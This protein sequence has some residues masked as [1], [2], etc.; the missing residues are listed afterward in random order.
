MVGEYFIGWIAIF[1]LDMDR[2]T[3]CDGDYEFDRT[4]FKVQIAKSRVQNAF[5][6]GSVT[7]PYKRFSGTCRKLVQGKNDGVIGKVYECWNEA[8]INESK[9]S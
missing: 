1:P 8:N 3:A 6:T 5:V 2:V 4:H 7:R 9:Y